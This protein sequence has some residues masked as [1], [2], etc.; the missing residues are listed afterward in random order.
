MKLLE[1]IKEDYNKKELEKLI[2]ESFNLEFMDSDI[3]KLYEIRKLYNKSLVKTLESIVEY[4]EMMNAC[5][6]E[7]MIRNRGNETPHQ[8]SEGMGNG[9]IDAI[10]EILYRI[11]SAIKELKND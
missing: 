6:N 11:K 1:T 9:R 8:Y 4:G 7:A 3:E 5:S 2:I 10:N